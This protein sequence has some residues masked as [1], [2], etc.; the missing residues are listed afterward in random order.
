MIKLFLS[1][2]LLFNE[3]TVFRRQEV[4]LT[5]KLLPFD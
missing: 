2:H 4:F 5:V 1:E 3:M